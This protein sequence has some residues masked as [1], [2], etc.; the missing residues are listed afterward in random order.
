ML[1]LQRILSICK[2][3][4]FFVQSTLVCNMKQIPCNTKTS[5]RYQYVIQS[6]SLQRFES[7]KFNFHRWLVP[8]ALPI[9]GEEPGLTVIRSS[10]EALDKHDC[11]QTVHKRFGRGAD[12]MRR[13][14]SVEFPA[15]S[16]NAASWFDRASSSATKEVK[17]ERGFVLSSHTPTKGE[18]DTRSA[19]PGRAPTR[20][21]A[22]ADT[23]TAQLPAFLPVVKGCDWHSERIVTFFPA[24]KTLR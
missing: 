20:T 22:P 24:K 6:K 15:V 17:G 12:E 8:P 10:E 11:D 18:A 5:H 14:N 3:N 1:A 4:Q 2:T 16:Q 23:A 7:V 13:R 21:G 19:G 9:T